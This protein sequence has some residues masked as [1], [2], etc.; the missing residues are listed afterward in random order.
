MTC[1]LQWAM[2]KAQDMEEEIATLKLR[3]RNTLA[4]RDRFQIAADQKHFVRREFEEVIGTADIAEATRRI[5]EWKAKAE[6][7]Q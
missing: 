2:E 4:E 6:N 7:P 3:L 5:R 1:Y